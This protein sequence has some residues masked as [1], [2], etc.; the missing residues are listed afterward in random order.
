MHTLDCYCG[1]VHCVLCIPLIACTAFIA[2]V[3]II[4]MGDMVSDG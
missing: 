4:I 3:V 1:I 2:N